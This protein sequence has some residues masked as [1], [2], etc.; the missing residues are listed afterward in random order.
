MRD[1]IVIGAP[2]GGGAT[3]AQLASRLPS[4][5]EAAVFVV[6]HATPEN[7]ILLA[8]VLN[9]PGRMRA[10]EAIEGETIERRRIYV[11]ADGKHLMIRDEKVRLSADGFDTPYRPSIDALFT[12]AADTYNERVIAVLL[13]HPREGGCRGLDIVRK[14]GGRTIAH[15][16]EEMPEKPCHPET[17]EDLAHDHLEIDKIVPRLVAYVKGTDGRSSVASPPAR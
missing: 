10:A 2:V 14:A 4:D 11:A 8:D 3:L 1:I 7:P 17:L 13:L 15:R 12:S 16:N 9:G 5:L 6:L